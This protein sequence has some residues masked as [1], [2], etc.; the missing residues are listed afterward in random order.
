[1]DKWAKNSIL[2]LLILETKGFAASELMKQ[3]E[4]IIKYY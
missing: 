4:K 1:M 2:K 3:Y